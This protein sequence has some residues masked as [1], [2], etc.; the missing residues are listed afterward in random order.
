MLEGHTPC[1]RLYDID[2]IFTANIFVIF[3]LLDRNFMFILSPGTSFGRTNKEIRDCKTT[4]TFGCKWRSARVPMR[5]LNT[6]DGIKNHASAHIHRG[7]H[8]TR[9]VGKEN[10][11]LLQIR[12]TPLFAHSSGVFGYLW[13]AA[14][15][16]KRG[17]F[18]CVPCTC[19]VL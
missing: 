8:R 2:L 6:F 12:L 14:H 5:P 1:T 13:P 4:I 18:S 16:P 9:S 15:W 3:V 17:D 10:C 11:I 19:K 7:W